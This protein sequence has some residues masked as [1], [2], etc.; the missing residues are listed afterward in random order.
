MTRRVMLCL[1]V[2]LVCTGAMGKKKSVRQQ[3]WPDG[4]PISEWFSDT[5]RVDLSALKRYVVTDYGVDG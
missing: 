2:A 1:L 5:T 4:T 3:V